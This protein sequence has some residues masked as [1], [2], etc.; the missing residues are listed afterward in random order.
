[1]ASIKAGVIGL[2]FIGPAH[3]EA[4]RR[5]GDVEVI[6]VAGARSGT[7][8]AKAAKLSIPRAYGN[9]RD[10]VADPDVQGVHNCTPNL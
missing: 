8:K 10:L 2:G 7:A 5:L 1:M 6:A 4:L 3:V 9:W